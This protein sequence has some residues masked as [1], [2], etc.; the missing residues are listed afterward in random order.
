MQWLMNS[1]GDV[2]ERQ[3]RDCPLDS[4]T[5]VR[6][7]GHGGYSGGGYRAEADPR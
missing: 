1:L 3:R 6:D 2:S 7:I 4:L 5:Y